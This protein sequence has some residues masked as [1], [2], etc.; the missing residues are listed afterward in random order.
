MMLFRLAILVVILSVVSWL[1]LKAMNKPVGL[2]WLLLIWIGL[3][4]FVLG[5]FYGISTLIATSNNM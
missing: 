3:F 2:V 4:L 5:S 1:V